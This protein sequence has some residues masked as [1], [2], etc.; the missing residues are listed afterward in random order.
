MTRDESLQIVEM[1]ITHWR[2]KN[3]SKEEIDVYARLIQDLDAELT[4]H[5][6]SVAAKE[7][8]YPPDVASLRERVRTEKRKLAPTAAPIKPQPQEYPP[9]VKRWICARMLYARW[10]KERD[11]RRFPEQLDF[12]DY[13]QEVMPEGAWDKEVASLD[14]RAFSEGFKAMFRS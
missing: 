6:I 2:V 5:C 10:D 1:I 13:T 14:E 8:A 7:I 3:W 12:G 9:W 11:M 4:V